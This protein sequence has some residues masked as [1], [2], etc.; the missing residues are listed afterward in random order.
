MSVEIK[1]LN[2]ILGDVWNFHLVFFGLGVSIFTLIYSFILTKRDELRGIS[3]KLKSGN[4]TPE[5]KQYESFAIIYILKLK[6]INNHALIVSITSFL[7]FLSTW[8]IHRIIPDC[9]YSTKQVGLVLTLSITSL[10]MLY[11]LFLIYKLYFQY[12]EETKIK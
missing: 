12:K 9:F 8:F 3:S 10:V 11:T 7:M 2:D 5:L 4:K 1:Q 6:K